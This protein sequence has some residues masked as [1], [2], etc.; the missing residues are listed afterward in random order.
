MKRILKQTLESLP[1]IISALKLTST[2]R[3]ITVNSVYV[4]RGGRRGGGVI[5]TM[6]FTNGHK[7]K[8]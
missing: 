1:E 4:E 2:V 8:Y 5:I 6:T 7:Y 3:C